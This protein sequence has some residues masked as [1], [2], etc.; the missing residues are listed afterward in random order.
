M[1]NNSEKILAVSII[2]LLLF[3]ALGCGSN[4]NSSD[5]NGGGGEYDMGTK[6]GIESYINEHWQEYGYSAKPAKY[7]ALSFDD[8]PCPASNNG[9]TAAL[10]GVLA[11]QKVKA[12]FFVIGSQVRNNKT[13][14]QAIFE[15]GHELGNHSNGWDS[16]GTSQ[17]EAIKTSLAA[18]SGAINEI[19]GKDPHLFR[20]PNLSHGSNLSQVCAEMGMALI[21]GNVH[22]DWPGNSASIKTSVLANPQNGGIIILHEN[23]TSQGNTMAV[24]PDI[25]SGL[26][27]KGF[28]IMTVSEL[29][30]VKGKTLEAGT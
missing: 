13:A 12:T 21:D 17:V 19:T 10:L 4:G 6:A 24:L 26:R 23:N 29:A 27:E 20:A 22:N 11:E 28:W 8:G 9:G 16:L 2:P 1:I 25:I 15:A 30:I 3:T 7:I 14:A 5:S 18:A